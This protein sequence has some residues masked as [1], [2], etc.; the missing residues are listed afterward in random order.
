MQ[1]TKPDDP[2]DER[3]H[4]FLLVVE[5]P[6]DPAQLI[7]LAIRVVVALLR[8]SHF[9]AR[10]D[11]RHAL[12]KHQRRKQ[13][14]FLTRPERAYR[15]IVGR[16]FDAAVPRQVVVVPVAIVFEVGLVVLDVVRDEI[17]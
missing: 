2:P 5:L 7:V 4:L 15:G 6:V 13:I 12:R 14:A 3:E 8:A 11:H 17:G 1:L 10:R 16:T 9:I